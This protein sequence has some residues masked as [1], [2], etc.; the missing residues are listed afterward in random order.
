MACDGVHKKDP[1]IFSCKVGANDV[2]YQSNVKFCF[3][4]GSL[5]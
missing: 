1:P 4:N 5:E 2:H 3:V